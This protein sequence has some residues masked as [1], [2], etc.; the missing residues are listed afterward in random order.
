MGIKCT[1]YLDNNGSLSVASDTQAIDYHSLAWKHFYPEGNGSAKP[2]YV[3]HHVDPSLRHCNPIR[4]NEWRIEDLVMITSAEHARI[5]HTGNQYNLGKRWWKRVWTPS[6]E[7]WDEYSLE[8]P[9]EFWELGKPTVEDWKF[10]SDIRNLVEKEERKLKKAHKDL[11]ENE[12]RKAAVMQVKPI[13]ETKCRTNHN[14]FLENWESAVFASS[15]QKIK[16]C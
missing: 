3:L 10:T 4:Y 6:F 9:G 2:G 13:Y 11:T 15:R 14:Y 7:P 1:I 12:L 5:H 8:C 16:I